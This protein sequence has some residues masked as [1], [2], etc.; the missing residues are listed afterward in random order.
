MIVIDANILIYSLIECGY[1]PLVHKLREKDNLVAFKVLLP[2]YAGQVA[3]SSTS[4]TLL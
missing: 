1:S 4:T 2:Y 3:S